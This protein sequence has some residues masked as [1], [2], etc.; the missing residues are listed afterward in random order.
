MKKFLEFLRNIFSLEVENTQCVDEPD[1]KVE[2]VEPVPIKMYVVDFSKIDTVSII[3]GNGYIQINHLVD[4][5]KGSGSVMTS[6]NLKMYDI[7]Q[8]E[9][10]VKQY[11]AY[12]N[13]Y[14]TNNPPPVA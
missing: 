13:Q 8:Y 10:V 1:D 6:F 11:E 12:K 3:Y 2:K 14:A 7:S 5:G 4:N 9:D